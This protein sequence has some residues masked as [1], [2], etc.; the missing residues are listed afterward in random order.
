MKTRSFDLKNEIF[1]KDDTLITSKTDLQ[2]RITYGNQDFVAF[3]GFSE[4]EFLHKPHNLIRHPLMPRCAFKLLWD[5]LA[6]KHEFFAFVMNLNKTNQTY[7]VFANITPSYDENGKVI[8]YYSVRRRPSKKGVETLAGIYQALL[9][10]EKGKGDKGMEEGVQFVL[11][12]LEQNK[13]SWDE[14]M[15][16][17]QNEGKVGGYR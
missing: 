13:I 17:L 2:G 1:L 11:N 3:S 10:I 14:L 16:N 12:F 6:Q 5:F 15:I 4:K 8:S 7:W 9:E